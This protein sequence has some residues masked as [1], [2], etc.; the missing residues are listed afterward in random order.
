[1]MRIPLK[2]LAKK[3][4]SLLINN[5][6]PKTRFLYKNSYSEPN[7][8]IQSWVSHLE[9]IIANAN[10]KSS[11][12]SNAVLEIPGMSNDQNRHFLNN[13]CSLPDLSYLEI[14]T[15][16]GSTL[17][18]SLYGNKKNLRSAIAID[19]WKEFDGPEEEFRKNIDSFLPDYPLEFFSIDCYK[20]NKSIFKDPINVYYFDG[21]HS[22]TAHRKA[23]TYYNEVFADTFIAVIDDWNW[24]TVRLGTFQAFQKLGYSIFYEKAFTSSAWWNGLYIAIL[25]K[26]KT[27]N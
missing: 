17:I 7:E 16:K 8:Q 2:S 3:Y 6:L 15:W 21:H 27:S 22:I 10:E 1:M 4:I 11:K 14:G 18:S 13:L 12:L 20:I 25:K 5:V 23:F 19:N 24:N 9:K 26:P